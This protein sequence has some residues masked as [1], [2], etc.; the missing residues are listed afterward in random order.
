[1]Q[2]APVNAVHAASLGAY[3]EAA[4][5]YEIALRHAGHLP[6][7][8][9][10]RLLE[11][12]SYACYMIDQVERAIEL[13]LT[14]LAMWRELGE[15]SQEG[16]TLRWLSRLT[17]FSGRRQE[18]DRY[19][20]EAVSV[21]ETLPP[22]CELA[23]AY[24]NRAQL[25]MLAHRIGEG[26]AVSHRA[27][28]LAEQL[29]EPG[30]LSHALNNL[31]TAQLIGMNDE[32]WAN[33]ER[34]LQIA[35]EGHFDEHVARSYTNLVST[36]TTHRLYEKASRYLEAGLA[37][38]EE[39]DLDSWYRYML[40]F[41]AR[42]R[43]ERCDWDG[44][45]EDCERVLSQ[46]NTAAV[47]RLPALTVLGHTRLRRGDPG[48]HEA[49]EQARPLARTISE[50]Q[51]SGPL[52]IA[53]ADLAVLDGEP[54]RAVRELREAYEQLGTSDDPWIRSEL[55][56][57]LWRLNALENPPANLRSPYGQEISGDWRAAA[58]AWL[59]LECPYEAATVLAVYGAEEGQK[60][61]LVIFDQLGALPAARAL[62]KQ[63]R[64][65]GVRSVPRGIREST[66]TNEFGLT[67]RENEI[68]ALLGEGLRNA[69]MAKRLFVS[70]K[71]VDHH[72]SAI[73]MKLGV[74]SRAE[75]VTVAGKRKAGDSVD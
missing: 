24:S 6:A 1:L 44:A 51:R 29:N 18:A 17:W 57:R 69:E 14:T 22:G 13:R 52:A 59:K 25:A 15:R 5:H 45:S 74:S 49:L 34:S 26:V 50:S 61:A 28:A 46:A 27:I 32:G 33:L 42:V 40:A 35:L 43:F 65:S 2:Y 10:L 39:R 19:A 53:C 71:T 20:D 7:V 72:V 56:V 47:N 37:Y 58:Q 31:G 8:E 9:R 67:K 38:C 48:A 54:E 75:A 68:L 11:P 66:R 23:M 36:A 55:A 60:E 64:D 73:L 41:R 63:M 3:R 16:D 62:R 4:S 30:I 12:Y 70:V 21:L